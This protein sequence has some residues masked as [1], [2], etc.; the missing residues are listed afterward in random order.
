MTQLVASTSADLEKYKGK[1]AGKI[2][3]IGEARVPDPSDK[4]LFRREDDAD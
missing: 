2:V 1:L 4:P 3:L